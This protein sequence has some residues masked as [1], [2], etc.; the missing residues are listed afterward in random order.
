VSIRGHNSPAVSPSSPDPVHARV[1][2]DAPVRLWG[3]SPRERL[4]RLLQRA[5]VAGVG[6]AGEPAPAVGSV[7][8]VRGDW[9]YDDRVVTALVRTRG[10]LLQAAGGGRGGGGGAPR[11][12][13]PT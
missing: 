3:L 7:V 2:G 11:P 1:L 10:V 9:V 8:L 4:V 13:P 5:G 12:P 6:D